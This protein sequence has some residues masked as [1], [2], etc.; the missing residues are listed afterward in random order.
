MTMQG[1]V[2]LQKL[3]W[4][5]RVPL[6]ELLRV[7]DEAQANWQSHYRHFA[8]T[9][10]PSKTRH[11]YE[12][13]QRLKDIHRRLGRLVLTKLD[14]GEYAHGGIRHR[15]PLT[16]AHAHLRSRRVVTNDIKSFFPSVSHRV[17]F[18]TLRRDHAFGRDVAALITR[19]TTIEGFLK[20]GAPTS[21]H[22]ANLVLVNSLDQALRPTLEATGTRYTRYVD[23]MAFSGDN[24]MPLISASAKLLSRCGLQ[25]HRTQRPPVSDGS[26]KRVRKLSKL[27][28]ADRFEPQVI[29]G[30]LVN[31]ADQLTYPRQERAKIR[32]AI[33]QLKAM[34][35]EGQVA[36]AISSIQGRIL[37]IQALHPQE[38]RRLEAYLDACRKLSCAFAA[39]P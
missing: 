14:F 35:G 30:L 15:S 34:A 3:A 16:H 36:S 28:I 12:P 39:S 20:E 4:I 10:G 1:L 22:L 37:R 5:I 29:T 23:D 19:L 38:A 31:S 27:K 33:H 6:E 21:G 32:S 18:A 2:S 9:T 13:K 25:V 7:A 24:P 26:E 17:V 11:I 8:V